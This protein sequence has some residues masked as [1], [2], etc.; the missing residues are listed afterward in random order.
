[1]NQIFD[2]EFAVFILTNGRPEKVI[3]HRSLRRHGYEGKIYL[4]IDNLDSCRDA[5]IE[6]FG[7][8]VIVFD[9]M[10]ISKTFDTGDNFNDMRAIIYARNATFKIASDLGIKY[11][12]QLDDDYTNFSYRFDGDRNYRPSK[13]K[14]IGK[15]FEAMLK[16][17]IN[18]G[19]QSI[20]M[21]Q[22]G[23]FIGGSESAMAKELMLKRKAMNSFICSTARPFQFVGRVNEDVNT[24][25]HKASQGML[26]LTTN[27]VSLT[28]KQTQSSSG[29]MTEMYLDSGTYVKS[30]YSVMYHPSGVKVGTIGGNKGRLHH[31][32]NWNN[33]APLILSEEYKKER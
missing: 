31:S 16:F 19:C 8:D 27:Q 24:Y 13:V 32:I 23:D 12:I 14:K 29:G 9:K 10:A 11:F 5:Y 17:Y 28:Q 22:G 6:K 21:A 3:T 33:T 4:I 26:F 20:A 1:M 7:D 15:V 2:K 18:T 25:T 30:F